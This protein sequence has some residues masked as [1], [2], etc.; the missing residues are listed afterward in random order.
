MLPP[1]PPK[2]HPSLT[3]SCQSVF[4]T[5]SIGDWVGGGLAL[6]GFVLT[7]MQARQAR[8]AAEAA[9]DAV[10]DTQQ[11]MTRNL[12]IALGPD[13]ARIEHALDRSIDSGD[14]ELVRERVV[15]WR[16]R[17]SEIRGLL[18][19]HTGMDHSS[20]AEALAESAQLATNAKIALGRP[21]A[22]SRT[23]LA[24][25]TSVSKV[26]AQVQA[27]TTSLRSGADSDAG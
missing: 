2:G 15:E 27:L 11:E 19:A 14:M 17:A 8:K 26:N 6:I 9:R 1:S 20:V 4:W 25:T 23:L 7:F 24:L 10:R 5:T 18:D 16:Q 3:V 13:L 21:N 12:L 22:N